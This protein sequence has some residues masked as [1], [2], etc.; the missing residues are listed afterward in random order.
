MKGY[1]PQ[2]MEAALSPRRKLV[3]LLAGYGFV[4]VFL[5]AITLSYAAYRGSRK[6]DKTHLERAVR[7]NPLEAE[8]RV[9]AGRRSLLV[10]ND[11]NRAAWWFESAVRLNPYV[12]RYWLDLATARLELGDNAGEL[13]AVRRAAAVEPTSP[14]IAWEAATH[15]IVSG[16]DRLALQTFRTLL[17][18][19][20]G[21]YD[22]VVELCWR[23]LHDSRR[24]LQEVLP[25]KQAA[26]LSLLRQLISVGA[27]ED[28]DAVWSAIVDLA[29]PIPLQPGLTYVDEL[30]LRKKVGE[31]EAAWKSLLTLNPALRGYHDDENLITNWRWEQ[32]LL[33]DGFDWRFPAAGGAV[34]FSLDSNESR[35]GSAS[36]LLSF[37]GEKVGDTGLYQ[38]VPVR[39]GSSYAFLAT[40]KSEELATAMPL[41]FEFHDAYTGALATTAGSISG[42]SGGWVKITETIRA[43]PQSR[44][45][46]V[47]VGQAAASHVRGKLW[48]DYV[49]IKSSGPNGSR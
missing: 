11:A 8:F 12:G 6:L 27:F 39:P 45:L 29:Q 9:Q 28:A 34:E 4:A 15:L 7:W 23:A 16:H 49:E 19:A 37:R 40:V 41:R 33:N 13:A 17:I 36:L 3:L 22:R 2:L 20:P 25:R 42:T 46:K 43:G 10:D 14:E 30:I 44:L 38:V 18:S 5:F 24:I 47:G 31:A 48:I 1:K 21:E 35:T 32:P 26:Y